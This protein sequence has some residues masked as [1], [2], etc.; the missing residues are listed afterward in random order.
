MKKI[1]CA[2]L[3]LS[4]SLF[5]DV[6][7]DPI[8]AEV[9]KNFMQE[10]GINGVAVA[11]FDGQQEHYYN[12]GFANVAANVPVTSDT[13]FELASITKVFTSTQLAIEI[14]R[15]KMNLKDPL[16]KFLPAL[17]NERSHVDQITLLDLAT[18]TSSLPRVPPPRKQGYNHKKIINFLRNWAPSYPVG[19]KYVYSNLGFGLL[20]YAFANVEGMDYYDVIRRD[21]LFPLNMSSTFITVPQ[22]MMKRY[23]QGYNKNGGMTQHYPMNAWPAGGALRST[24]NDMMKFLKANLGVSGPADLLK[25]MQF[26]QQE[27]FKV[28]DNLTMGLG[29]QRFHARGLLFVDKNGGVDGFSSYIG[30]L[31]DRKMGVVLLANK[32]K[33]QITEAGRELLA[34][35]V[36][37]QQQQQKQK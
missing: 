5:A 21:I 6:N 33:T 20:G 16:V 23:A 25:A 13:I 31:P 7:P 30:M 12:F 35:I 19:T 1:I 14:Q 8:V 15:G 34:R 32:A 37:A 27:Q 2:F 36:H 22:D 24:A 26:A 29:W 17:K 9:I 18:H 3:L 4:S 11:Y 10:K 28:N